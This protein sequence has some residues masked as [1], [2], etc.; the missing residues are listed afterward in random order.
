M[1]NLNVFDGDVAGDP[2]QAD[3]H[4]GRHSESAVRKVRVFKSCQ[5]FGGRLAEPNLRYAGLEPPE[6]HSDIEPIGEGLGLADGTETTLPLRAFAGI[7]IVPQ[8]GFLAEPGCWMS[9]PDER[10]LGDDWKLRKIG[11]MA[12]DIAG[13]CWPQ[14]FLLTQVLVG[15]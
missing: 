6:H 5:E 14:P 13:Y 10:C 2:M 8:D 11:V 9:T 3:E 7:I 15:A 12:R 1:R 4:R